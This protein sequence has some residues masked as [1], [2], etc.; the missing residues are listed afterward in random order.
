[1]RM[2]KL[3]LAAVF[4]AAVAMADDEPLDV[5]ITVVDSPADLPAAVTKTIELPAAA[6]DHAQERAQHGLDTANQAR[7]LG[8]EFGQSI[9]EEAKTKGK[10]NGKGPP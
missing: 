9:A 3:F 10:G 2:P 1:M 8:R 6:A 4:L 7:A 5:T